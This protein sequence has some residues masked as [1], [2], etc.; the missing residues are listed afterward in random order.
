[1]WPPKGPSLNGGFAQLS[2]AWESAIR[3]KILRCRENPILCYPITKSPS[4]FMA[5]SGTGVIAAIPSRNEIV[6]G[7]A[8]KSPIIGGVIAERPVTCVGSAIA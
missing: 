1:M 6:N 8:R 4:S 3:P 5:V 7:G 2:A